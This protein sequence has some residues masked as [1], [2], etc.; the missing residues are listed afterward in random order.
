VNY[1]NYSDN[2]HVNL[3]ISNNFININQQKWPCFGYNHDL[4]P[5]LRYK[6][7]ISHVINIYGLVYQISLLNLC[8]G[9]IPKLLLIIVS[10]KKEPLRLFFY[11]LYK[12][13]AVVPTS[14]DQSQR[15]FL[16]LVSTQSAF[17]SINSNS[18][19]AFT[20]LFRSTQARGSVLAQTLPPNELRLFLPHHS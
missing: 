11:I 19:Q 20:P 7:L 10:R 16:G 14:V 6:Q 9:P 12:S 3:I 2:C 8:L 1:L 15:K 18:P 17:A 13:S 5:Y 4:L